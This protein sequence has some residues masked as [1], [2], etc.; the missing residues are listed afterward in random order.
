VKLTFT[1]EF[2]NDYRKLAD[3]DRQRV[4]K[5]L[6]Q[7]AEDSKYPGLRVKKM[8]G[9]QEFWEARASRDLRITFLMSG[10]SIQL[11]NVGHHNILRRY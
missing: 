11:I 7:L 1:S 9:R 10:E 3:V 4:G 2:E 5:A 8:Q 6:I